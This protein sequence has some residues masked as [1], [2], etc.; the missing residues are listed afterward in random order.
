MNTKTCMSLL[1]ATL[2]A[3]VSFAMFT[4]SSQA[5]PTSINLPLDTSSQQALIS[6]YNSLASTLQHNYGVSSDSDPTRALEGLVAY[7]ESHAGSLSSQPPSSTASSTSSFTLGQNAFYDMK[8]TIE[9]L[10]AHSNSIDARVI[11]AGAKWANQMTSLR[12]PNLATPKLTMPSLSNQLSYAKTQIGYGIL[13]DTSLN[14]FMKNNPSL[15]SIASRQGT[16]SAAVSAAWSKSINSAV[17]SST[18]SLSSGLLDQCSA[19]GLMALATGKATSAR[20]SGIGNSSCGGCVISGLYQHSSLYHIW[21]NPSSA[22]SNSYPAGTTSGLPDWLKSQVTKSNS[23]MPVSNSNTE[24]SCSQGSAAAAQ[25]LAGGALD[26]ILSGM[27]FN[28]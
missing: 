11:A 7:Q 9:N 22:T 1:T 15:P 4:P 26:R 19:A 16:S 25:T 13:L 23:L 18:A 5:A 28:N 17:Q 12:V 2:L 10:N 27:K 6:S 21:D 3:G 8:S 24:V 14:S 20:N